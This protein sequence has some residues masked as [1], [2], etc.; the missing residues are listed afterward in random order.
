[1]MYKTI[2]LDKDTKKNKFIMNAIIFILCMLMWASFKKNTERIS[3]CS[4]K[5]DA[6]KLYPLIFLMLNFKLKSLVKEEEE[7]EIHDI[8][9]NKC[10]VFG[11]KIE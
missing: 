5:R 10:Y 9:K 8:N 4:W 11:N 1:M 7:E 6:T 2:Y 3:S